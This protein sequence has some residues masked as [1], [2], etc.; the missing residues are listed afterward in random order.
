MNSFLKK[1]VIGE[2]NLGFCNQNFL[3]EFKKVEKGGTITLRAKWVSHHR[4]GS[5][6]ADPFIYEVNKD[7]AL[8]LAEEYIFSIKKGVISLCTI[9]RESAKMVKRTV[10][11][12]ESCHLSY[13]FYD[14]GTHRFAPES[15]RNNNW[16]SYNFD[17]EKVSDKKIIAPEPFIDCTPIEWNGNW[18]LFAVKQPRALDQLLIF[19]SDTKYGEYKPHP[20]NPI[21]N[22]IRTSRPGGKCF[23]VDGELYRIVQDSTGRY[24]E[25]LHITHVKELTTNTFE[26][27]DWCDIAIES[28]GKYPL[29]VHTLNFKEDFIVIDGFRE[30]FRPF[31]ATYIYKIVPIFKKF[32]LHK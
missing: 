14:E 19:C 28:D 21:K 1:F 17:G 13:P 10:I 6:F 30:V 20:Q 3:E 24:G 15:S 7:T 26:E 4:H 22:C 16:A 27:E 29:G 32:G 18:Y 23:V 12:E 5:F 25:S 31:F 11:L 8:I 9:N 2:W